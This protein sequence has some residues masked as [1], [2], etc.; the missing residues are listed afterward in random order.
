MIWIAT[1]LAAGAGVGF[2]A[3]LLGIGGG[4]TLVPILATLF[5]AQA[6][7][8]DYTVHLAL[9]TGMASVLFTSS[10]SVRE[11]H[12]H[13]AV[14]WSIVARIAPGMLLG[15]LSSTLAAGWISQRTLALS[16]AVIVFAGATQILVGRK[17]KAGR[18]MPGA[19]ATF[20][21]SYAIGVV[22]GLVSAG[23]AFLTIPFMLLC[24][25]SMHRAIGT[26][27][28]IGVPVALVGTIG[29]VA[30]GWRVDALPPTALGFVY[31]PA[32]VAL[33]AASILTAPWGARKAHALP[34]LTLKRVFACLLYLLATKMAV[35]AW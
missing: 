11:H 20:L 31:V 12:R 35:S 14:D 24:G 16:F 10:A 21:V 3:G 4:M 27:A 8:P 17:P 33:V 26:A 29:Y 9:G 13:A 28:A 15:A 7:A 30:G 5:G 1:Y 19:V 25:V 22:C 2:L 32:L 18:G 23:G 6:L 34:V